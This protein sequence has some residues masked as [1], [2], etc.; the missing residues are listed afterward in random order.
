LY[1][2][3]RKGESVELKQREIYISKF[4]LTNINL[5]LVDFEIE[6]S[7]GTYIRSIANDFGKKLK[8][9]SYLHKLIRTSIGNFKLEN[10]IKIEDFEKII[11]KKS[12]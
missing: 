3:A 11:Q 6:C 12:E 9:G 2:Y 10:A 4:K 8:V 1:D 5:P 7:K